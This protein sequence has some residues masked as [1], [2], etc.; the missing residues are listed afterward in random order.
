MMTPIAIAVFLSTCAAG[1]VVQAT[2]GFGFG[3]LCMAVFPYILPSYLQSTA[4]SS[5]CAA[6]MSTMV[7]IRSRKHINFKIILPLFLGYSVASVWSVYYAKT[8]SEGLMVKLL[9]GV[10][11]LVSIYFMFF[12]GKFR[13]RPTFYNGII[14]GV[15]GGVGSGMFSIGGPPVIIYLM[16]AISDKD[17]YRACSVTYFAIGSWYVSTVRWINGVFDAQTV[18]LWGMA[19]LALCVGTYIGNRIFDRIN[20]ATLKRLVYCFMAVSGVTMLF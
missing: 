18:Y 12:S 17:E 16:S 5:V 2:T 15:L 10:L 14:A 13:I 20:A 9:G 4:V 3:I 8:Q 7:A 1:A 19:I 11:I 6:T